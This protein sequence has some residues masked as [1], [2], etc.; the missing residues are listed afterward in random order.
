MDLIFDLIA[1]LFG[2]LVKAGVAVGAL[3]WLALIGF[4]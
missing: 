2:L 3:G 1:E 4:A